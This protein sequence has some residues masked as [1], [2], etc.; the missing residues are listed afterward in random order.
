[1]IRGLPTLEVRYKKGNCE[2]NPFK[3][4]FEA[5][6]SAYDLYL[7]EFPNEIREEIMNG[8]DFVLL[9]H[10]FEAIKVKEYPCYT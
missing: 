7:I 6:L 8:L 5:P 3:V 10:Y 2:K 9:E 4:T 1:M